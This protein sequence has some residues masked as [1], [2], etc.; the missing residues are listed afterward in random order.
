VP[1]I[2]NNLVNDKILILS[3]LKAVGNNG[4]YVYELKIVDPTGTYW[5]HSPHGITGRRLAGLFLVSD[6]QE[7]ELNLPAG[8]FDLPRNIQVRASTTIT[9]CNTWIMA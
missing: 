5:F 1:V 2:L 3:N 7:E 8:E 4:T 9:S 6:Q